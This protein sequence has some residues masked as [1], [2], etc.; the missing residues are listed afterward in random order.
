MPL[1]DGRSPLPPP[2]LGARP[3][4]ILDVLGIKTGGRY[5]QHL[6]GDLLPQLDLSELYLQQPV[7]YALSSGG[8]MS[9][10][11]LV[12][13]DV[14]LV[15]DNEAWLLMAGELASDSTLTATLT[16]VRL[17]LSLGLG[18]ATYNQTTSPVPLLYTGRDWVQPDILADAWQFSPYVLAQP[19]SRLQSICLRYTG[20]GSE[21]IRFRLRYL[22]LPR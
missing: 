5:P 20:S 19:G 13:T 14:I 11:G 21:T 16:G 1:H 8:T 17:G 18:G 10:T 15:P 6:Y 7:Q 22:R 3:E 4:G 2:P 12:N 9:G